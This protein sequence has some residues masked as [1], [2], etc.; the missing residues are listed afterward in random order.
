MHQ[1]TSNK[2][3]KTLVVYVMIKTLSKK[4][5]KSKGITSTQAES[6]LFAQ[7]GTFPAV[8]SFCKC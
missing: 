8:V 6:S 3:K 2:T 4:H 5:F 1:G 7:T